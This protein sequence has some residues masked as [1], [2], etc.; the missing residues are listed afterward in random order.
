MRSGNILQEIWLNKDNIDK[1]YATINRMDIKKSNNILLSY[2]KNYEFEQYWIEQYRKDMIDYI[3]EKHKTS[4]LFPFE[5]AEDILNVL[6]EIDNE[7]EKLKRV[8]SMK[9]F[10]NSKYFEKI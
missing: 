2:L 4:N 3:N 5:F 8:L 7:K 6:K 10:G 1:T 9:C